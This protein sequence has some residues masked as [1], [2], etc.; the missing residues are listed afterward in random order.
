MVKYRGSDEAGFK[1]VSG[2]LRIMLKKAG[3]KVD[4]NWKNEES[5]KGL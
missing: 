1:A 2:T 4:E 5:I 3:G